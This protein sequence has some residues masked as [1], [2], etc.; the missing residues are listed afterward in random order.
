MK[1]NYKIVITGG[2]GRFGSVLQ[3]KYKSNKLFYPNKKQLNILSIRTIEKYLKKIKPKFLIHLAGL[4][5]PMK[6]HDNN[7]S[8]SIKLNIIGTANIVTVCSKLK[9]KL[10]YFSTNYV[11]EGKKG[12]YKETDPILPI[13]NYAWSKLGG[14]ASVRM[15]KN[16]LILRIC[17]TEKPFI[18]KKAFYNVRTNFIFQEQ[19]AEILFK[20]LNYKGIINVGGNIKTIYNFAKKFN[21][22]IKKI[23]LK[24]NNKYNFP[25]NPSMN[26]E[27]LKKIL[28]NKFA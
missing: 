2:S 14:E 8:K 16:S 7:I 1:L 15:Y 17:M 19:I 10:I 9:I 4:S 23:Y 25:L 12:N 20:I 13:N 26:I 6:I 11:Y 22:N 18:H 3:K 24:K 28:N 27:R 5:R 21:S